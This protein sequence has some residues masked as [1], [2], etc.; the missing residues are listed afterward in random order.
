MF[1]IPVLFIISLKEPA[2]VINRMGC[3]RDI[4]FYLTELFF[5]AG[6]FYAGACC[7]QNK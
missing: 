6:M 5:L 4:L 1:R 7:L 2:K 3:Y